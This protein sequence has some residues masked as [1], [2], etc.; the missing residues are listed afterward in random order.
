[1]GVAFP[2]VITS[3]SYHIV[4]TMEKAARRLLALT[5]AA[6]FDR[7]RS[8]S[9]ADTFV[10]T[11]LSNAEFAKDRID[12]FQRC[13]RNSSLVATPPCRSEVAVFPMFSAGT[14]PVRLLP[15]LTE[16]FVQPLDLCRRDLP[17]CCWIT[18]ESVIV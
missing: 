6:S 11:M 14:A 10:M 5:D 1:M 17:I 12:Y 3:S 7:D 13:G 2:V 4:V 15:E 9:T 8:T 16:H 18:M